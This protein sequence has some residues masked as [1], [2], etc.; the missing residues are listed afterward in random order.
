MPIAG[1]QASRKDF[2]AFYP[3]TGSL[4]RIARS[5]QAEATKNRD[6][7]LRS[8]HRRGANRKRQALDS[9][10]SDALCYLAIGLPCATES[11]DIVKATVLCNAN[12][13]PRI[14]ELIRCKWPSG[15]IGTAR[16]AQLL[17][18]KSEQVAVRIKDFVE[19]TK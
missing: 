8:Q 4:S 5:L 16:I 6:A 12:G 15:Q 19:V 17:W 18:T 3:M 2:G 9:P 1:R 11:N 14:G 7:W 10:C 13:Q